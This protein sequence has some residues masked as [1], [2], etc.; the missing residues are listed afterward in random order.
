MTTESTISEDQLAIDWTL[1]EQDLEFVISNSRGATQHIKLA[2]QL[3]YLRRYGIFIGSEDSVPLDAL[4]Y[5]AKQF[6][7]PLVN[8]PSFSKNTY[9]YTWEDKICTYLDYRKYSEI[10]NTELESWIVGKICTETLNKD[11]L[12]LLVIDNLKENRVVLPSPTILGRLVNKH[13]NQALDRFYRK[14]NQTLPKEKR[15]MLQSLLI[16]EK[17]G[18]ESD[19]SKLKQYPGN[20]NSRM[21]NKFLDYFN[22]IDSLGILDCDLT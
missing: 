11:R 1:T 17:K 3:C 12:T 13:I 7:T 20:A 14:I 10:D 6:N 5:L 8:I 15:D 19:F 22:K 21:M 18:E 4:S 2:A 16:P 9:S